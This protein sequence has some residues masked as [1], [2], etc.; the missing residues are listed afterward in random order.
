MQLNI[1]Q[2]TT[3][4]TIMDDFDGIDKQINRSQQTYQIAQVLW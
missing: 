4:N 2:K 1:I 3:E